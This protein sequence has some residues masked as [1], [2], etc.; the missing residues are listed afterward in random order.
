M[1][2]GNEPR[3]RVQHKLEPA[4]AHKSMSL[5]GLRHRRFEVV[6]DTFFGHFAVAILFKEVVGDLLNEKFSQARFESRS[7]PR[8][9]AGTET[10]Q[11]HPSCAGVT[12]KAF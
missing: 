10:H 6:S 1:V 2:V 3:C 9:M 12:R 4:L 11:E 8:E 7:R 5:G